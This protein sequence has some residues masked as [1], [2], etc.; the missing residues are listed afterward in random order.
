MTN[1]KEG[2]QPHL[3]H[4]NPYTTH[5][6]ILYRVPV[7]AIYIILPYTVTHLAILYREPTMPYAYHSVSIAHH[8]T[9][10]TVS[11]LAILYHTS[12]AIYMHI[13]L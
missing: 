5:L 6:A 9:P 8:T 11:H 4:T 10:F 2:S 1:E 3:Y 12:Q 13:I 7:P